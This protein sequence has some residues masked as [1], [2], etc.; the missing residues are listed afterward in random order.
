MKTKIFLILFIVFIVLTSSEQDNKF[1]TNAIEYGY[2]RGQMDAMNNE[3]K[4]KIVFSKTHYWYEWSRSPWENNAQTIFDPKTFFGI[5]EYDSQLYDTIKKI[6][7]SYM[8]D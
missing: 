6:K 8:T 5:K 1:I 7:D 3:F 4:I 2:F